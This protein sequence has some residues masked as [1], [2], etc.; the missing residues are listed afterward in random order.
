MRAMKR[1]RSFRFRD[2]RGI[3][4]VTVA[5]SLMAMFSAL[6]LSIDSG[7]LWTTR[8]NIIT[9]TDAAVL[10]AAR[11]FSTPV[12]N[13]GLDPCNSTHQVAA[14]TGAT[15]V[16]LENNPEALHDETATPDGWQVTLYDS[17]LCGTAGFIPGKVRFDGRLTSD[18]AFS[19]LFGFQPPS[20]I[21]SSTAAW[22]YITAAGQGL[23]P[24]GICDQGTV[25]FSSP[26]P[27]PPI[28]D[29]GPFPHYFLWNELWHGRISR[30]YYDSYFGTHPSEYPAISAGWQN[31]PAN[32]PGNNPNEGLPYVSPLDDNRFGLVHRIRMPD[33]DCGVMPGNRMWVD[34]TGDGGGRPGASELENQLLYGY[35]GTVS[36]TP[37]DCD[38]GDDVPPPQDC[39]G[40][41]GDAAKLEKAL[42]T[43]TCPV[44]IAP[45]DCRYIFPIL[46]AS[47]VFEGGA[48]AH[49]VQSAF[50]TVVL[51]GFGGIESD[52]DFEL[53]LEFVDQKITGQIG[54]APPSG[55]LPYQTGFQLCGADHDTVADRCP[56]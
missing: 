13:G 20:A 16:L 56:F 27:A 42:Q 53:D 23:R 47:Q 5:V 41:S 3:S 18:Q 48:N 11:L 15:N 10:H 28:V 2:E 52:A 4:A 54:A 24:I 17:S 38:P 22:G 31:G 14:E 39:G 49:Y 37:H 34:F 50:L 29:P 43:L 30:E 1:Y 35:N 46:V 33:T 19:S 7:Q 12:A 32:N 55:G 51:R 21:S 26:P 36:L 44:A 9:G 25:G 40:A 6:V 45:L 8:R